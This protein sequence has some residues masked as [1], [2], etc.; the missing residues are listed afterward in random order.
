MD[1][2]E[3]EERK[4]NR[5]IRERQIQKKKK[6][7]KKLPGN[8]TEH[9]TVNKVLTSFRRPLGNARHRLVDA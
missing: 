8:D 4:R 6:K 9:V 7:K 3:N 1:N 5:R 2:N